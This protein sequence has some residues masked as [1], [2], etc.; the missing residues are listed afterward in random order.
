MGDCQLEKTEKTNGRIIRLWTV[1]EEAK[2]T[3]GEQ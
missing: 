3:F 2:A 1:T